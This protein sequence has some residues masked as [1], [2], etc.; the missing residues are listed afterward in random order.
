MPIDFQKPH[1]TKNEREIEKLNEMMMNNILK[2]G[3]IQKSDFPVVSTKDIP[4]SGGTP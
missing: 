3:P 4:T 2:Q 1:K